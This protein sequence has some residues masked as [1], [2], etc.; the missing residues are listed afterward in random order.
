MVLRL[1]YPDRIVEVS[2]DRVY[3][4]KGRLF[5][6]PLEEVIKHYTTGDA[7]LPPALREV[8]DSVARIILRAGEFGGDIAGSASAT[9]RING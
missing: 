5:S 3:V 4:F 6:A 7:L 9:V 1:G 2:D 8:A